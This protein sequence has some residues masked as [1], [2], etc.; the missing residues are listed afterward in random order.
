MNASPSPQT[1]ASLSAHLQETR[2]QLLQILAYFEEIK[3]KFAFYQLAVATKMQEQ[4]RETILREM[5]NWGA[6]LRTR[7][8]RAAFDFN[9]EWEEVRETAHFLKTAAESIQNQF[10]KINKGNETGSIS[11]MESAVSELMKD[12]LLR[13]KIQQLHQK[14]KD[15][16]DNLREISNLLYTEEGTIKQNMLSLLQ[17]EGNAVL[18]DSEIAIREG[19]TEAVAKQQAS[20]RQ[21]FGSPRVESVGDVSTKIWRESISEEGMIT[22]KIILTITLSIR[23]GSR[24]TKYIAKV[25]YDAKKEEFLGSLAKKEMFS[26]LKI[27]LNLHYTTTTEMLLELPLQFSAILPLLKEEQRKSR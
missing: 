25:R 9:R 22:E 3:K 23:D 17:E 6:E 18:R 26:E 5:K 8:Q 1:T 19:V 13:E 7:L 21:R 14:I 12:S 20:L 10:N 24:D 4:K 15:V 11:Q 27:I 2:G 16:E